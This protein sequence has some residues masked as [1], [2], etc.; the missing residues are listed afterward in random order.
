LFL[1][2]KPKTKFRPPFVSFLR[3]P[4]AAPLPWIFNPL[5]RTSSS[6]LIINVIINHQSASPSITTVGSSSIN[7]SWHVNFIITNL[8][9][10]TIDQI[11]VAEFINQYQKSAFKCSIKL[12]GG[13]AGLRSDLGELING[14]AGPKYNQ[15]LF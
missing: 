13:S 6:S 4:F 15:E 5:L 10:R 2:K 11:A 8:K 7:E 9:H 3:A 12:N 14:S 1:S